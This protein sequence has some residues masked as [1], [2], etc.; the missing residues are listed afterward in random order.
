MASPEN[1]DQLYSQLSKSF[2]THLFEAIADGE[3]K[4]AGMK[5]NK[6]RNIRERAQQLG[7]GST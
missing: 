7:F 5:P 4:I 1:M 2:G 3:T 6:I